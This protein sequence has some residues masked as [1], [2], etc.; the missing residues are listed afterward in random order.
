VYLAGSKARRLIKVGI[1][2][3]PEVRMAVIRN[4]SY[5]S[6]TDW[7]LLLAIEISDA[8]KAERDIQNMLSKFRCERSY[9]KGTHT[10][11]AS[12]AFSCGY[13]IAESALR[14]SLLEAQIVPGGYKFRSPSRLEYQFI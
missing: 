1:S 9:Q 11:I 14:S 7:E 12:E 5:A 6:A 2:D 10:Q 13:D 8:G 3:E 4:E